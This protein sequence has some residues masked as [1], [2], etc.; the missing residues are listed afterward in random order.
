MCSGS[1]SRIATTMPCCQIRFQRT[2]TVSLRYA[3]TWQ[4][5]SSVEVSLVSADTE[6]FRRN[7][8]SDDSRSAPASFIPKLSSVPPDLARSTST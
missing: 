7:F 5:T 4:L 1:P 6:Y 3:G 2:T 8:S